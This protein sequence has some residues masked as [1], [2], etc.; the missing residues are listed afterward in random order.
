MILSKYDLEEDVLTRNDG[1][2]R[3]TC[4]TIINTP[5]KNIKEFSYLWEK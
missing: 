1:R 3:E 2:G 4:E 5:D